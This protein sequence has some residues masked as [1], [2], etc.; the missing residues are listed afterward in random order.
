MTSVV[1]YIFVFFNDTATPGSYTYRHTRSLPDALPT[2]QLVLFHRQEID[3]PVD[4]HG[5]DGT[6]E[7]PGVGRRDPL[8][9]GDQRHRVRPFGP[10]DAVVVLPRDRK[11]TRLNSS[12]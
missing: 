10:D 5:F 11:S 3:P 12:H 2:C 9:A 6:D 7:I 8:L 1:I 4:R